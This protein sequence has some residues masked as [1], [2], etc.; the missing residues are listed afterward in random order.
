MSKNKNPLKDLDLFLKQQ[1]AA[2]VTPTPLRERLSSPT[3][4]PSA[5]PTTEEELV[6]RLSAL[7][8]S[9]PKA[10]F[11]LIIKA[12]EQLQG[13]ENALLINTALYLKNGGSW[14]EAVREYWRTK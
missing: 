13:T 4:T 5:P 11:D 9:D 12:A 6:A 14:E 3:V 1:A 10:L 8:E 2:F 7:A